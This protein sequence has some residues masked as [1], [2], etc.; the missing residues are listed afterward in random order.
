[1]RYYYKGNCRKKLRVPIQRL[2]L[3]VPVEEIGLPE[4]LKKKV[5]NIISSEADDEVEVKV[6]SGTCACMKRN[7]ATS[8]SIR[9]MSRN[10]RQFLDAVM[11][12]SVGE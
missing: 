7:F 1:M 4:F 6:K 10:M 2:S 12:F 3:I 9:I 8:R 5:T 11:E